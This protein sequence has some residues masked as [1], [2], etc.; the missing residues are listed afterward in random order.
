MNRSLGTIDFFLNNDEE[1][2]IHARSSEL[3]QGEFF[4]V[5]VTLEG[6]ED[7]ITPVS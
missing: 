7:A 3:K 4:P 1:P 5:C 6:N 2:F